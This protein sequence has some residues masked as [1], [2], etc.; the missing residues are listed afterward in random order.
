VKNDLLEQ[1]LALLPGP[2][3]RKILTAGILCLCVVLL[4][5]FAVEHGMSRLFYLAFATA[6]LMV[7]LLRFK[8][9]YAIV[10][11]CGKAVGTVFAHKRLGARRGARIKYGF[12]STDNKLHVGNVGG[13]AFM[14]NEGQSLPIVYKLEDPSISLPLS[15]FWFYEFPVESFRSIQSEKASVDKAPRSSELPPD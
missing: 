3:L 7:C 1:Q 13:T 10:S 4:Y 14:R 2:V 15:S 8:R 5:F 6:I 11:D 12:L 9:E